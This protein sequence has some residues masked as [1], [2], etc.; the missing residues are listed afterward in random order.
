M[1]F[2]IPFMC[3]T[4]FQIYSLTSP[5]LFIKNNKLWNER[6]FF[7]YM[8]ASVYRVISKNIENHIFKHNR[9]FKLPCIYKQP[10]LTKKWHYNIFVQILY[11]YL[12]YTDRLL[13][14]FFLLL[15]VT[16]L[17]LHEKPRR[18]DWV[19]ESRQ[20]NFCE[21][22]HFS[23]CHVFLNMSFFV[24][25]FIHSLPNALRCENVPIYK[26]VFVISNKTI[27]HIIRYKKWL[28]FHYCITVQIGKS[29]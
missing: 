11:S 22:Y 25:F 26:I 2:F 27:D 15:V 12:R 5:V 18:K 1:A 19:I 29:N 13:D 17:E 4:F 21:R 28:N 14:V 24:G 6:R 7:V 16:F 20:K 8:T 10:V 9:I 3:V 23:G